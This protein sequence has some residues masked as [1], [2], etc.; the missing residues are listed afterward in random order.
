[1]GMRKNFQWNKN[2]SLEGCFTFVG[3]HPAAAVSTLAHVS[4]HN[5]DSQDNGSFLLF[6]V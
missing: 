5:A 3:I 1:M 4:C 6:D 2:G